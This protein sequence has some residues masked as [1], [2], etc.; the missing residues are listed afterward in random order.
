VRSPSVGAFYR[1]PRPDADPFVEVGDVVEAG[2][3]VAVIESMKLF[4]PV[5]AEAS[6]TVVEVLK[7]NGEVVEHGEP[8]FALS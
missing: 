2:Q 4:L 3:Q 6:G 7:E 1:A 8:L 5:N